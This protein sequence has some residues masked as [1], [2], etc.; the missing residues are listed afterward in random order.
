MLSILEVNPPRT[1]T[2]TE[3]LRR[4]VVK[5]KEVAEEEA[6]AEKTDVRNKYYSALDL[7]PRPVSLPIFEEAVKSYL[8]SQY[9]K[10]GPTENAFNALH[11]QAIRAGAAGYP[12][13]SR[14]LQK[15]FANFLMIYVTEGF[16]GEDTTGTQMGNFKGGWSGGGFKD[17]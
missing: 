13:N 3:P 10:K 4:A 5:L 12:L 9:G 16:V 14:N 2:P 11:S 7:A 15:E 8:T 17:D 6:R 1:G